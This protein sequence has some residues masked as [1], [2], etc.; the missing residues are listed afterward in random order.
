MS[1]HRDLIS[2]HTREN[3]GMS[4]SLLSKSKKL[5]NFYLCGEIALLGDNSVRNVWNR[6]F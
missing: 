4:V 1:Y 3:E 6:K 5:G 2:N